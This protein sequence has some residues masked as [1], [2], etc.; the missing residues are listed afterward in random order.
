MTGM[1]LVAWTPFLSI[2]V[3]VMWSLPALGSVLAR[4]EAAVSLWALPFFLSFIPM[5]FAVIGIRR[6]FLQ[7]AGGLGRVG[8]TVSVA[9]SAGVIAFAIGSML[10]GESGSSAD[11]SS[12]MNVAAAFCVL[13]FRVGFV[14]F[15]ADALRHRLLP[16]WHA[17]P[18]MLGCTLIFGLTMDWFGVPALLFAPPKLNVSFLHFVLS[19]AC[20]MLLGLALVDQPH[21]SEAV[22]I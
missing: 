16:R 2:L 4:T 15:G 17:L 21:Q 18:L 12:W 5:L 13:A 6:R 3:G 14:L 9:G 19:G 7:S 1:R 10:W 20:W 11:Y 22:S 8:L